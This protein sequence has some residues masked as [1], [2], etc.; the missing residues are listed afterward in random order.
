MNLVS[1]ETLALGI[2]IAPTDVCF[3]IGLKAL[4]GRDGIFTV[5]WLLKLFKYRTTWKL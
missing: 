3:L 1:C 4:M 5:Q 2:I